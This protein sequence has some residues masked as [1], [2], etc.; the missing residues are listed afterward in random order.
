MKLILQRLL[1]PP[2][3]GIVNLV[4]CL[5]FQGLQHM[6]ATIGSQVYPSFHHYLKLIKVVCWVDNNVK[7]FQEKVKAKHHTCFKSHTHGPLWSTPNRI[8]IWFKVLHGPNEWLCQVQ[9]HGSFG[10]VIESPNISHE[11]KQSKP[12]IFMKSENPEPNSPT[13]DQL[14]LDLPIELDSSIEQEDRIEVSTWPSVSHQ[15]RYRCNQRHSR[16]FW[17][18]CW[19]R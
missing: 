3:C 17:N 18:E 5:N 14:H 1:K 10:R 16:Y 15:T 8:F 12:F 19:S 7:K 9:V 4:K 6:T 2:N 11:S 13:K